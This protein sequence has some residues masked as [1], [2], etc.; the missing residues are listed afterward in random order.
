L[1]QGPAP[2]NESP[3]SRTQ[4]HQIKADPTCPRPCLVPKGDAGLVFI[5]A[6]LDARDGKFSGFLHSK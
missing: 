5:E 1:L 3:E 4:T 6:S 2:E